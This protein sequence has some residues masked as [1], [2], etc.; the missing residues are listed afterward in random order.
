MCFCYWYIVFIN[1]SGDK[2][3][4][5][6]SDW[7]YLVELFFGFVDL[8]NEVNEVIFGFGNIL[9]RLISELELSDSFGLFILLLENKVK[10]MFFFM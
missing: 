10:Y 5:V 1:L 3:F 9:F 6:Y 2:L 7:F 4:V 8:I